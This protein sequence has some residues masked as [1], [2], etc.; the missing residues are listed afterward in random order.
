MSKDEVSRYLGVSVGA[1][2]RYTRR[3][4]LT[5]RVG[6]V[7]DLPVYNEAEVRRLKEEM[8]ARAPAVRRHRRTLSLEEAVAVTGLPREEL[9]GRAIDGRLRARWVGSAVRLGRTEVEALARDPE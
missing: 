8:D 7:G 4:R 3:G 9:L 6:S 5:V 1:V 2:E